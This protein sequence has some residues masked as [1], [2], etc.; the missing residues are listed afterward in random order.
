MIKCVIIEDEPKA[1]D[2]LKRYIDKIDYLELIGYCRDGVE[3]LEMLPI[4]NPDLIFLDINMPNINGLELLNLVNNHPKIIIT[5]AYSEYALASYEFEVVDYLLKPI[6]FDKFL[7]SINRVRVS[8]NTSRQKIFN[9]KSNED[10]ILI[11][12]GSK[13]HKIKLIDIL[14]FKKDGNYIEIIT[15]KNN[16]I[17]LRSNMTDVFS[18]V[19][20]ELFIRV[21]RSYVVSLWK[22]SILEV[23]KVII[24]N[25]NIPIGPLYR[26]ELME[27]VK[28]NGLTF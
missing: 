22:I 8:K 19:P 17:L 23:N 24:K 20:K 21:H 5:S 15:D 1:K 25:H 26:K 7:R 18:L 13:T 28:K 2:V 4:L 14:F 9:I 16:K 11:K 10:Y 3:A 12:S 6:R 27:L